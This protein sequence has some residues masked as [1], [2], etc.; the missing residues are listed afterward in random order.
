[1]SVLKAAIRLTP[2][3]FLAQAHALL[4]QLVSPAQFLGVKFFRQ[5]DVFV[6]ISV[7]NLN[8]FPEKLPI[9]FHFVFFA[10]FL[11]KIRDF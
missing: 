6:L 5:I 3:A 1:M 7:L 2:N 10:I 4:L 8:D 11:G 9:Y